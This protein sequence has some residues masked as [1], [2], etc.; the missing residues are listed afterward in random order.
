M[1]LGAAFGNITIG[2]TSTPALPQPRLLV[3][4]VLTMTSN[5]WQ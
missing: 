3:V 1:K 4:G 2:T 5:D